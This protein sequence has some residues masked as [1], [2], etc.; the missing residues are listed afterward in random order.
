MTFSRTG[1]APALKNQ[2]R[3]TAWPVPK[4]RFIGPGHVMVRP[5]K[6][7]SKKSK[8]SKKIKNSKRKKKKNYPSQPATT[9]S[10]AMPSYIFFDE[11]YTLASPGLEVYAYFTFHYTTQPLVTLWCMLFFYINSMGPSDYLEN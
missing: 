10:P 1:N 7:M 5:Y 3:V 9:T 6:F 8:R 11:I 4:N 2:V